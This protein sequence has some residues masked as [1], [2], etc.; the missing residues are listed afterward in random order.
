[1]IV[2]LTA[3]DCLKNPEGTIAINLTNVTRAA[4]DKNG[5]TVV[6]FV[7]GDYRFFLINYDNFVRLWKSSGVGEV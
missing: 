7:G 4:G 5:L 6:H 2:Q 3:C 1:M